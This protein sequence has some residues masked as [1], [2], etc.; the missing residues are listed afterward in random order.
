M[1]ASHR[2]FPSRGDWPCILKS[3]DRRNGL[4]LVGSLDLER[5]DFIRPVLEV[6]GEMKETLQRCALPSFASAA[7]I[8]P[9]SFGCKLCAN[10]FVSSKML[11]D[12][13]RTCLRAI[14]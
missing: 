7:A 4:I 6:G 9:S 8:S 13:L 10:E 11:S 2:L 14:Q 1:P 12:F 3:F 5:F